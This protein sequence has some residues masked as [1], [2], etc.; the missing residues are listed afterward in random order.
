MTEN[1]VQDAKAGLV[2]IKDFDPE[3]AINDT[4]PFSWTAEQPISLGWQ[5]VKW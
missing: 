2:R 4:A 5:E 1:R 3:P